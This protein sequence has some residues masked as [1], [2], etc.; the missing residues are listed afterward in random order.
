MVNLLLGSGVDQSRF[1]NIHNWDAVVR[2]HFDKYQ[3]LIDAHTYRLQRILPY[4]RFYN[5]ELLTLQVLKRK[6]EVGEVD[7]H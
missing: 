4:P 3:R 2:K 7:K 1:P 6:Q 5:T